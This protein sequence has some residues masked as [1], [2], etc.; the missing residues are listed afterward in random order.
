M[1]QPDQN[2]QND[3]SQYQS[4]LLVYQD[5]LDNQLQPSVIES[6]IVDDQSYYSG[7]SKSQ[8]RN[9]KFY[10]ILLFIISRS[11]FTVTFIIQQFLDPL[12]SF[13]LVFNANNHCFI[14]LLLLFLDL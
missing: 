5:M 7:V 11:H 14:N 6:V 12:R 8:K 13:L 9:P 1:P 10:W 2:F 3:I 4:A